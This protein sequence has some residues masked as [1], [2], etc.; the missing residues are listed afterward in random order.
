VTL[1]CVYVDWIGIH[2]VSL[3]PLVSILR[4]G[5]KTFLLFILLMDEISL[6]LLVEVV[7][8]TILFII[9]GAT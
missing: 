9:F 2:I 6:S 1:V 5:I 3:R 4:S 7:H 8:T